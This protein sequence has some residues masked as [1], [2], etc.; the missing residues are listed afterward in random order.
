MSNSWIVA[1]DPTISALVEAGRGRGGTLTVVSVGAPPE[2]F[3]GVDKVISLPLPAATPIEA[4]APR[5][6]ET[7]DAQPGDLVLVAN[8]PAARVLAGAVAAKLGAPL[9]RGLKGVDA[10]GVQVTRYGGMSMQ[11]ISLASPVVVVAD[12]GQPGQGE[13]P[14]IETVDGEPYPARV[15]AT[16][17][18]GSAPVNLAAAK[19]I[20][21]VGR[22][23][24]A[25]ADLAMAR[26]LAEAIG[27]EL[28]C[29][30]PIAEGH[31][32]LDR[33][34][35]IGVSGQHVSPELYIALGISGQLQ[36]V[37]GMNEAT[38]VVAVNSDEHA[39][40]FGEADYGIV[41]DLYSIVPAMR[42]ALG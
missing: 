3:L 41:G 4:M 5:V 38:V 9:L 36:H 24:K 14:T 42:A 30:R 1:V 33:D 18:A 28:A 7:V 6:A 15:V 20:V 2:Q 29:S 23:F 22:G 10:E 21:A 13:A 25:E 34:R 31:G 12:G 8:H 27:A 19:R 26:E 16:E 39:P 32:W 11:T 37:V 35:Y 17:A 40:I